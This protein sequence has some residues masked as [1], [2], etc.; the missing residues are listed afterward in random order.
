MNPNFKF[1]S[2]L[3]NSNGGIQQSYIDRYKTSATERQPP[4]RHLIYLINPA[5]M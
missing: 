4:A 3:L 1:E 2:L 5:Q